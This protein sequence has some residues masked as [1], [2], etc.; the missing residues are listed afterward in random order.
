MIAQ[1]SVTGPLL[2]LELGAGSN[3]EPQ[4]L[5]TPVL[6]VSKGNSTAIPEKG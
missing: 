5:R 3:V 2:E 4:E 1:I 6:L